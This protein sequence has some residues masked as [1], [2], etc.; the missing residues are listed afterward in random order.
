MC[1]F[2]PFFSQAEVTD[3]IAFDYCCIVLY[4]EDILKTQHKIRLM[5]DHTC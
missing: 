2:A 4:A 5:S 3:L 1:I